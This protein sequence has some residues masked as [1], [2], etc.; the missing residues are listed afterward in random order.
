MN[1]KKTESTV[2]TCSWVMLQ[3]LWGPQLK[4]RWLGPENHQGAFIRRGRK[5]HGQAGWEGSTPFQGQDQAAGRSGAE[6]GQAEAPSPLRPSPLADDYISYEEEAGLLAPRSLEI[7][8]I[9]QSVIS[10]ATPTRGGCET[11]QI[12]PKHMISAKKEFQSPWQRLGSR[13]VMNPEAVEGEAGRCP[14]QAPGLRYLNCQVSYPRA[15]QECLPHLGPG[16]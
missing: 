10:T 9:C 3:L 12:T 4:N 13:V 7:L 8:I 14:V 15:T 11:S 2:L 16:G 1:I 6:G 5:G